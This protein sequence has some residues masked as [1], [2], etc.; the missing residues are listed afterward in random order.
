MRVFVYGPPGAG[1]TTLA[2][3][4]GKALGIPVHHL[5]NHFHRGPDDHVPLNEAMTGLAPVIATADWVIEGN[6][7]AGPGGL[8]RSGGPRHRPR[9]E[10]PPGSL[11]PGPA[12]A[13]PL[14]RG[15]ARH[16]VR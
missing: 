9:P 3:R 14:D 12:T 8:R 6:H 13:W 1:K 2:L 16:V 11:P 4:L 10:S 15:L 7:V 5:D